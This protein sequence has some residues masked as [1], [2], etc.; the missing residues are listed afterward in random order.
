MRCLHDTINQHLCALKAMDCEPSGQFITSLREMK[1]DK[2]PCL[3]GRSTAKIVV[4]Y[5]TSVP[6]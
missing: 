6:C 3:N 1:L 4:A 2:P 5:L